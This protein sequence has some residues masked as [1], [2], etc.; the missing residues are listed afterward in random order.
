[1][2]SLRLIG[3]GEGWTKGSFCA[4]CLRAAV[5]EWWPNP[6]PLSPTSG[7][8]GSA[9]GP[10]GVVLTQGQL[11]PEAKRLNRENKGS[12]LLREDCMAAKWRCRK[13]KRGYVLRLDRPCRIPRIWGKPGSTQKGCESSRKPQLLHQQLGD[14]PG[15]GQLL[16]S[17]QE[18]VPLRNLKSQ[19]EGDGHYVLKGL[20]TGHGSPYP[21]HGIPSNQGLQ[22]SLKRQVHRSCSH[23]TPGTG[24]AS[25]G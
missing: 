10:V 9:Q 21:I 23:C 20:L 25:W 7:P 11:L 8:V 5:W 14:H 15:E 12:K 22:S 16:S 2:T 1:M 18:K 3:L 24:W 17:A 13:N 19:L 4:R 6:T